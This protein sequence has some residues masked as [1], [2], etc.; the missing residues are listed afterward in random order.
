MTIRTGDEVSFNATLS[1]N[2]NK[3]Y[4]YGIDP[5]SENDN[6]SIVILEQNDSHRR[7]VY[8]WT[9]SRQ[10][11]MRERIKTKK[12]SNLESF[13]NYCARKILDLT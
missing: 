1:G 11:M 3:K 8:S 13:Y 12:E 9:C 5:A 10:A 7:I 4:I 2:P 6:F